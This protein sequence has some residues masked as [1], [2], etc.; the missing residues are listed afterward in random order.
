[1]NSTVTYSLSKHARTHAQSIVDR[2]A[3]SRVSGEDMRVIFT[4]PDRLISVRGIDNHEID[5]IP[6]VIAGGISKTIVGDVMVIFHQ[7][8]YYGN[9]KT[10]HSPGQIECLKIGE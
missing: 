9:G 2:G 7:H 8:A 5:S 4:N 1:M 10:I 3:N 6:M